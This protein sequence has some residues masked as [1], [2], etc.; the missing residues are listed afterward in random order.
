[1]EKERGGV[2]TDGRSFIH[3]GS[4]CPNGPSV[5]TPFLSFFRD[6]FLAR[7]FGQMK[8]GQMDAAKAQVFLF[9]R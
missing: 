9:V 3:A 1:M 5:R 4:T 7:A 6:F 8:S 2:R